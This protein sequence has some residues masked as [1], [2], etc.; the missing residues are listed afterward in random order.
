MPSIDLSGCG[1]CG[2]QSSGSAGPCCGGELPAAINVSIV[3]NGDCDCLTQSFGPIS[4]EDGASDGSPD[5][6]QPHYSAP[7]LSF[8]NCN[9]DH[10]IDVAF[11]GCYHPD[12]GGTIGFAIDIQTLCTDVG[13]APISGPHHNNV[14]MAEV[15]SCSPFHAIVRDVPAAAIN[16]PG[17]CDGTYDIEFTEA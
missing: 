4:R 3:G 11:I 6:F 15:L 8:Q 12:E 10:L 9:G 2:E 5:L 17:C 7:G 16:G 1:C 13:D 14:Y